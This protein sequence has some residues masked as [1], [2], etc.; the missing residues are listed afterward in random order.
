MTL[1]LFHNPS[2]YAGLC[3][4]LCLYSPSTVHGLDVLLTP[5]Q[6]TTG[7]GSRPT[8]MYTETRRPLSS[9]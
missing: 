1:G 2:T 5:G 3:T 8:H 7:P 6:Q 9:L 4:Q